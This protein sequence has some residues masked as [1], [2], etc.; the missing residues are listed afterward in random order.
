MVRL[1]R[2]EGEREGTPRRRL[3]TFVVASRPFAAPIEDV[4]ETVE[5]RPITPVF[6]MPPAV[7]G[8]TNLRGEILAVLD[9]GVLLGFRASARDPSARLVVIDHGKR[10]AALLVDALGPIQ[11]YEPGALAPVPATLP[12]EQ[13]ALLQGVLSL[14]EHPLPVLDPAKVLDAPDLRPFA[15]D[16]ASP[17]AEASA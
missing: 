15:A 1:K 9:V 2:G 11:A 5:L 7:T 3:V 17:Q 12:I 4:R 16:D 13:A 8:I 14:A 6:R 10:S